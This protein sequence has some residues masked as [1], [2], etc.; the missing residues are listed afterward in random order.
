MLITISD[1]FVDT[2]DLCARLFGSA[3][4]YVGIR[5]GSF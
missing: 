4:S 5:L 1:T 2:V 3:I